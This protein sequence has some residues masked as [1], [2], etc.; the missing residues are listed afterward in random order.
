[1]ASISSREDISKNDGVAT[2]KHTRP[3]TN[4]MEGEIKVVEHNSGLQRSMGNRQV[5]LLAIGGSIGTAT[6][7]SIGITL[8]HSGPIGLLLGFT[9]YSCILAL[10]NNA[11]AEMVVFMPVTASF[12]RHGS[13]WVDDAWGFMAGWNFFFYE[14][15]LIPFEITALGLVLSFWR[16]DI[17]IAAICAGCSVLYGIINLLPVSYYGETEFWLSGGKVLL[18]AILYCFT[19]ITMVGGNPQHDAY[20]FRHWKSPGPFV[21][22]LASGNSG[23]F[24]GF[25]ASLWSASFAVVGPE[26]LAMV[27]GEAKLPRT[28]LK[29]AF[30]TIYARMALMFV[31]SALCV[32]IVI[33]SND[34]TLVA[35][36]NRTAPG[37]G[38]GAASP[39]IIAMTNLGI[40]TLPHIVNALLVTSIFSAGNTYFYCAIRSLHGLAEDGHAPKMF[41]KCTKWG[42]PIY[43][44]AIVM[45]FPFL[46]FL[47]VSNSSAVVLT[48]LINLVT[49][50]TLID[51]VVMCVNFLFFY[52]ALKAQNYDRDSL[53]YKGF[54]QPWSTVFALC[55]ETLVLGGYGYSTFLPGAFTVADFLS[56][57][58][59]VFVAIFLFGFWKLVK[60]TKMVKPE[61]ADLVWEK[62]SIDRYEEQST[63]TSVGFT[64]F[65]KGLLGRKKHVHSA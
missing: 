28:T 23:K 47:Q 49:A 32:G 51:Y 4:Y 40:G 26:Y 13:K 27:A 19:F 35:I 60:R 61:E 6:F 5:Q 46:S 37:S 12:I 41:R 33:A 54:W 39:Y 8:Y 59:M 21:E 9:I 56:Y 63:E 45:A 7:V 50:T 42:T 29:R 30:K 1:M 44:W 20:G 58:T 15:V 64:T 14:A 11:V 10:V 25:L 31:G 36:A 22:Y 52:R 65:V 17:P 55:F 3:H 53:P 34:P 43:C 57:Y 2:E 16:D 48:W 24:Q 18:L 38:S 62:P